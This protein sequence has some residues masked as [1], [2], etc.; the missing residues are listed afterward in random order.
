MHINAT[1]VIITSEKLSELGSS[2]SKHVVQSGCILCIDGKFVEID[3]FRIAI[4]YNDSIDQI[5]TME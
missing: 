3:I 2:V 4:Q 1:T 5:I